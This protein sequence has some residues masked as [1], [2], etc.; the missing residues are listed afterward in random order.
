MSNDREMSYPEAVYHLNSLPLF[1]K[2]REVVYLATDYPEN[3]VRSLKLQV[4]NIDG[5]DIFNDGIIEYYQNRP[6]DTH[7]ENMPLITFAAWYVRKTGKCDQSNPNTINL[8][9]GKGAMMKKFKK[10]IIRLPRLNKSDEIEEKERFCFSKLMTYVPWRDEMLK[11]VLKG[12]NSYSECYEFHKEDIGPLMIEYEKGD[13][14]IKEAFEDISKLQPDLEKNLENL[15]EALDMPEIESVFPMENDNADS[16]EEDFHPESLPSSACTNDTNRANR[17]YYSEIRSLNTEQQKIFW[18]VL[19][20]VRKKRLNSEYPALHL[21]IIGGAGTGKT[22]VINVLYQLFER[23]LHEYAKKNEEKVVEKIS[24]TGMAAANIDGKTWH[25]FLN[26]G[27]GKIEG[28][29]DISGAA[30]AESRV[31]LSPIQVIIEDEISLESSNMDTYMHDFLKYIFDIRENIPYGGRSV[32]KVGDFMQLKPYGG[33]PIYPKKIIQEDGKVSDANATCSRAESDNPYVQFDKNR[34]ATYFKCF[35]LTQC[36]RQK[37]DQDFANILSIVRYMTI[38]SKTD[39]DALPTEQKQ[40]IEFLRSRVISV[41]HPNYPHN[42]LHIFPTNKDVDDYNTKMI[43]TVP[44]AVE[45]KCYESYLDQTGSFK[46]CEAKKAKDDFGLPKCII[47]GIGARVMI[48]KN[49][50]V[51]DKIVNGTI[52]T[53]LA[54]SNEKGVDTVWMKPDDDSVGKYKQSQLSSKKRKLYPKA[55]PIVRIEGNI[56]VAN[57]NTTYKRKQ[58]P[59]KLCYA[60]TIHKY[61]GRSLDQIV[62]GGFNSKWMQGMMYTALTRCRKAE[63]LF[64]QDFNPY[65]LKANLDGL[66]EIDRIR[67]YSLVSDKNERLD[68]FKNYPPKDWFYVCLQNVRSMSLHIED[69][70]FDPI[71]QSASILCLTE[72]SLTDKNW[73]GWKKFKD[74]EVYSRERRETKTNGTEDQRKSGG[75]AILVKKSLESGHTVLGN[76]KKNLEMVNT[77]TNWAGKPSFVSCIYKDHEMPKKHFIDD[78]K[79]VF[80]HFSNYP[81]IITG[82][83]NLYD[84]HDKDIGLLNS[85]AKQNG[86]VPTVH[87]G[88]TI[89]DHLLDQIFV[90]D[91]LKESFTSVNL[92][93][94]FSDHNLVVLCLKKNDFY[95]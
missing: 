54:L 16:E 45:L 37:D 78:M 88:T 22:K 60:A 95:V 46:P 66:H 80:E 67:K 85:F 70:L 6:T 11:D 64:L 51:D 12:F 86:F 24:F 89:N 27:H 30:K 81:S 8:I 76:I 52:G 19:D 17:S 48:T 28:L 63:G 83:F 41:D 32:V 65:C 5:D 29:K 93:S 87:Q 43:E 90:N 44:G 47:I 72:T 94:Y 74:F 21:G 15:E 42:A 82:D 68:F 3:R 36:M 18:Y 20:W 23:E 84:E 10:N 91:H 56:S 57:D 69:V 38:T 1:W 14:D 2:S 35:E 53:V 40:V 13:S 58:F 61:Q 75:V 77:V 92:P 9:N 39:L 25:S 33:A 50:N 49:Q 7:F 31:K 79:K 62:I 59:L 73:N 34:W 71:M 4:E 55:I 26:R